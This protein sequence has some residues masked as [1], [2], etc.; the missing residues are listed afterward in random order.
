MERFKRLREARFSPE[1]RLLDMDEQGVDVQI[2][3]PTVGGQLLGREFHVRPLLP[4]FLPLELFLHAARIGT[5]S[6]RL[7]ANMFADHTVVAVW[8]TL[9]PIAIPAVFMGLGMLVAVLQAFIFSLLTMIYIGLAMQ[10]PH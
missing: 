2:L 3:Y 4:L 10:E 9:V 7:L 6:L 1:A 5:L 8:I